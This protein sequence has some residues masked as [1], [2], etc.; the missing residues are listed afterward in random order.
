MLFNFKLKHS[1]YLM[2]KLKSKLT[3]LNDEQATILI[4]VYLLYHYYKSYYFNF[5][6]L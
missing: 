1:H 3:I 4:K 5:I 2:I 6:F